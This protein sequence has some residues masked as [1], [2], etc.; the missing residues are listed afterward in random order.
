MDLPSSANAPELL[1]R[2]VAFAKSASAEF[3]DDAREVFAAL[4]VAQLLKGRAFSA[5]ARRDAPRPAGLS[6][7]LMRLVDTGF[8]FQPKGVGDVADELSRRGTNAKRTSVNKLLCEDFM[9]RRGMLSRTRAEGKWKYRLA[10][11]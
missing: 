11:P 7:A 8:F 9:K 4:L 6:G 1:R 10:L 2:Q 5:G 3:G